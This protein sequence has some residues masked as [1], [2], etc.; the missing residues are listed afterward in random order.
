MVHTEGIHLEIRGG[1]QNWEGKT[2]PNAGE[3]SGRADV[4]IFVQRYLLLL[5]QHPHR[6]SLCEISLLR[7]WLEWFMREKRLY[8]QWSKLV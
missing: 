3:R 6:V 4:S 2:N 7:M 5:G 1:N 8:K